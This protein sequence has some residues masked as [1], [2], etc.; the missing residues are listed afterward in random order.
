MLKLNIPELEKQAQALVEGAAVPVTVDYIARQL[1]IAW[2]TARS[3]LLSMALKGQVSAVKTMKSW[4]FQ[5][6]PEKG[7]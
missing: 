3:L 6:A 7:T 4:I 5:P 1:H 2:D